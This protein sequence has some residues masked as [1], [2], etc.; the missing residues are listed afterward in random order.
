MRNPSPA[1]RV[2]VFAAIALG[3]VAAVALPRQ[4]APAAAAKP[5]PKFHVGRIADPAIP[6]S[7]GIIASRKHAGVYWTHNDSGNPAELF[8]IRRDGTL[9]RTFKVDAKNHDWEDVAYDEDGRILIADT[10][11]NDHRRKHVFVHA[12]L[13]PDPASKPA[14]GEAP[15]KVE[16]TW[17]LTYPA[18]PFDAESLFVKGKTGYVISKLLTMEKAGLY[19]FDLDPAKPKQELRFVATLPI[20]FPATAADLSPDG[21]WLAVMT[22]AGPYLFRVD[23]DPLKAATAPSKHVL[24]TDKNIEAITFVPEGTL[25]TTEGRE[26]LLFR[27]ADYGVPEADTRPATQPQ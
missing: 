11:N 12:V 20:R 15:L 16:Q 9:L 2:W 10:G 24:F 26:V 4:H 7:S 17:T 5:E 1:A 13:E 18:Q 22:I 25:A 21:R 6:E 3:F 23:G 8:A 14:P 27:W 19:A